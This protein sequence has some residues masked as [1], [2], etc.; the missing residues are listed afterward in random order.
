[1]ANDNEL[2]AE[3]KAAYCEWLRQGMLQ[4]QAAKAVGV[5]WKDIALEMVAD[6]DFEIAV[7]MAEAEASDTIEDALH[8]AAL[9]GNVQAMI[10][11]LANRN[12]GRW[13]YI[14]SVGAKPEWT[15]TDEVALSRVRQAAQDGD[16][17]AAAW[18][19]RNG[20]SESD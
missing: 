5:T 18:L 16:A 20:F 1:M 17:Q 4:G 10:T 9:G 2:T 6:H 13:R 14:G 8:S 19:K 3:K 15:G 11:W 7:H 12:P